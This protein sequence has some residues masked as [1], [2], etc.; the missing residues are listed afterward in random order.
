VQ[1]SVDILEQ[2][3]KR[4]AEERRIFLKE[5]R[6]LAEVIE[7]NGKLMRYPLFTECRFLEKHFGVFVYLN[8]L[9]IARMLCTYSP[10]GLDAAKLR[11][12]KKQE[13]QGETHRQSIHDVEDEQLKRVFGEQFLQR[14]AII[15]TTKMPN[16]NLRAFAETLKK[17]RE[18][19]IKYLVT[20]TDMF[21]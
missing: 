14:I 7:H 3:K 10:L 12:L 5:A 4:H 11:T 1:Q 2:L 15:S 9:E 19:E 13:Q 20:A 6:K 8:F 17:K 18:D 16:K 21:S